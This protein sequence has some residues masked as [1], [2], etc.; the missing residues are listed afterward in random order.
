MTLPAWLLA[1]LPELAALDGPGLLIDHGSVD[2]LP[3]QGTDS[4]RFLHGQT[5][6]DLAQAVAGSLLRSSAVNASAR[7]LALIDLLVTPDGALVLPVVGIVAH[8]ATRFDR[9]I[10]P[11]DQVSLGA[12]QRRRQVTLLG[13]PAALL[14]P[15]AATPVPARSWRALTCNSEEVLVLAGTGLGLPGCRLLLP[16]RSPLPA[17]LGLLDALGHEA[18]TLLEAL[19]GLPGLGTE[20]SEDHNPYALG[21]A[22]TVGRDKGCYVGQETLARLVSYDGLRRQLRFWR[23]AEPLPALPRGDRL[24]DSGG[25]RLGQVTSRTAHPAGGSYGLALLRRAGWSDRQ[26]V[27]GDGDRRVNLRLHRPLASSFPTD[28]MD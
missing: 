9:Y 3:L 15:L 4:L 24:L 17:A 16:P 11:A 25:G 14:A 28:S 26:V 8:L 12:L 10:F 22:A 2:L 7:M 21:L 6:Q 13:D 1:E 23:A 18:Q 20:L 19:V 5:T 27:L